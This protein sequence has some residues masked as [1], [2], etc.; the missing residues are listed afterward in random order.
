MPFGNKRVYRYLSVYSLEWSVD[1]NLVNVELNWKHGRSTKRITLVAGH[2]VKVTHGQ[3]KCRTEPWMIRAFR[4]MG[5]ASA[6][7]YDPAVP[8]VATHEGFGC[9]F[10]C[11]A[12]ESWFVELVMVKNWEDDPKDWVLD[13]DQMWTVPAERLYWSDPSDPPQELQLYLTDGEAD[14]AKGGIDIEW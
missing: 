13:Y 6:Q 8:L 12:D 9:W 11:R 2:L 14:M 7:G 10:A 5:A 3:N 4:I 1:Q